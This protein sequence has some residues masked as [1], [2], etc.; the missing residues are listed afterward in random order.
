MNDPGGGSHEIA[1]ELVQA[2]TR[3][4]EADFTVRLPRNYKRDH[5]DAL[6]F[7]VN[8]IAEQ[9]DRLLA[10]REKSR[11]ELEAGVAALSQ[12]FL[13]FAAGDFSIRA[14]RTGRGDPL[15]VL[16]GMFNTVAD[17]A[18]RAVHSRERQRAALE[19]I[20]EAMIDGVLLLDSSA[21]IVRS[22]G[23]MAALL[24]WNAGALAGR[25]VTD[26]LVPGERAFV[27]QLSDLAWRGAFRDRDTHFRD[28]SG[29]TVAMAVN[30][31]PQLDGGGGLVGIVLVARD[32]RAL[33]DAQAQLHLSD[34]LTAMGTVTAGIAHEIN[35]PLAFIIA[36][37]S[38]V[39]EELALLGGSKPDPHLEEIHRALAA[40]RCGA[41]RVKAIVR[42]LR[43]FSRSTDK[44]RAPLALP[45]VVEAAVGLI[46][47]EL[48]HSARVELHFDPTP[49]VDANEGRLVQLFLNL[50]QNAAQ[51]IPPGAADS[52]SIRIA[53]GTDR[54]GNAFVSIKDSGAGIAPENLSR[55]FEPFFTTKPVGVGTG[56]GLSICQ[57]IVSSMGGRIDVSSEPGCGCEF[58]VMLSPSRES[59]PDTPRELDPIS[60]PRPMRLLVVD[61]EPE[62]GDALRRILG[63]EHEVD[64]VT[65]AAHALRLLE[66]QSY[67]LILCDLLMPEMTGME[68][69]ELLARARPDVARCVV[70]MTAG[71]FHGESRAFLDRIPN[72]CLDKPFDADALSSLLRGVGR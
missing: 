34:R 9:L 28:A 3:L 62:V 25:P 61:D 14:Q 32:E 44:Q 2:F 10:D 27:T 72:A 50:L 26:I 6:A 47:N 22:N 60:F 42:D 21:T 46:R 71:P 8:L 16:A 39:S 29:G 43:A 54:L 52:N 33:Q 69:Y 36:N 19:A 20:L 1:A 59:V 40:S 7:F 35:N 63:R 11:V 15:D 24:G 57:K 65:T 51:A 45:R 48:R 13:A 58:R 38:F 18:G 31:S 64:A 56:L 30:G 66:A 5:A 4:A 41:E 70:F 68:L 12:R 49:A 37:L 53:T 67:D 17:E 55:V 23:A